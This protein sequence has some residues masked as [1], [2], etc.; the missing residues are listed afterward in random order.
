MSKLIK[1][2]FNSL[3]FSK[4]PK[5]FCLGA[6]KTGTTTIASV[7]RDHGFRVGNQRR[8]EL[9]IKDWAVGDYRRIIEYCRTAEA[10]QDIPFSYPDTYRAM[11]QAFPGSKFILTVRNDPNEWFDSLVRFHTKL[12]GKN[13]PPSADDLRSFS[14]IY[15]GFLWD[16]MRLRYGDDE[17]LLYNREWYCKCYQ[18][19][20]H[21]IQQYFQERP[22]DL[23]IINVAEPDA[24]Q[25]LLAFLNIPYTGQTM[26]HMNASK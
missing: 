24:M 21:A 12:I 4:R 7:F 2:W 16:A 19:H 9:L 18:E 3:F 6:N 14:Y 22:D 10:F 17:T 1:N 26:P 13:H 25:R 5:V 23:L 8:A 20:N 11:D 15:R